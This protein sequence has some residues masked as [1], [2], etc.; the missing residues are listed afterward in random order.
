MP[1]GVSVVIPL[2]NKGQYIGRAVESV[3]NQTFRDSEIIVV[4]DGSTDDG[5]AVVEGIGDPR[6]R[7]ISQKN[8]GV[9]AAR[10]RGV[11]IA[12][13]DFVAFLDA[14]D[15][16]TPVHLETLLKLR[17]EYPGAGMYSTAHQIMDYS[18]TLRTPGYRAIPP[19]PWEGLLPGFFRSIATG[20]YPVNAS[21]AGIP[22]GI[23]LEFGGFPE[24][25]WWGEDLDLFGRIALKYPVAFSWTIGAIYHHDTAHRASNRLPAL[26]EEPFVITAKKEMG[27]GR[28]P[29]E[30]A[31]DLMEVVARMEL[32]RAQVNL[33]AGN[34]QA[35]GEILR[36][37]A[38]REFR[39]KRR[40]LQLLALL[41]AFLTRSAWK[42]KRGF[43]A[44]VL[45]KD[46]SRDPW[47][48]D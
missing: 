30:M 32:A 45:R 8:S 42:A 33:K 13:S 35:A 29:P 10:N 9:S 37:L 1:A 23:F 27:E 26:Y 39:W 24:G 46:Y 22:R 47:L 12:G 14:D 18:G 34:R 36:N 11:R 48:K 38:T 31:R 43:R 44:L 2:Y 21:V 16:W 6:I 28:V 17:R 20:E 4:D 3:R 25:M 7:I 19:P 41:P 5:P 15:E 40:E